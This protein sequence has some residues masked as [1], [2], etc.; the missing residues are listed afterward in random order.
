VSQSFEAPIGSTSARP[1]P[2]PCDHHAD[3]PQLIVAALEGNLPIFSTAGQI[4]QGY[5]SLI[6]VLSVPVSLSNFS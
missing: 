1:R 5:A 6:Q 4:A 2:A 3:Q